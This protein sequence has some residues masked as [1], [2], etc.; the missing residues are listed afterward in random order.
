MSE[1]FVEKAHPK[2]LSQ[3]KIKPHLPLMF[4]VNTILAWNFYRFHYTMAVQVQKCR[5]DKSQW[6][7]WLKDLKIKA[8]NSPLVNSEV[9]R[10]SCLLCF[11]LTGTDHQN[12]PNVFAL[13]RKRKYTEAVVAQKCP[14]LAI[15][16]KKPFNGSEYLGHKLAVHWK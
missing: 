13:F 15:F 4:T 2:Y 8:Q 5:Q 10:E 7:I 14:L 6:Q 12:F 9:K 3:L 11:V 1:S 16:A